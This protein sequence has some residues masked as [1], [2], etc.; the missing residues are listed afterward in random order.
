M[1]QNSTCAR[2]IRHSLCRKF[3]GDPIADQKKKVVF[4]V[5]HSPFILDFRSVEDVKSVVSFS[6]DHSIPNHILNLDPAATARLSAL[7]PRLNVHHKQLFFSDN[8]IFVEGILLC[9][10]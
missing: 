3:A 9:L 7:V 1:S 4:L 5:T 2:S 6:L 10:G 8:P